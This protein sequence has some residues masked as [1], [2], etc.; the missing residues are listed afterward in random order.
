MRIEATEIPDLFVVRLEWRQDERG[1]FA[2]LFDGE[3]FAANGMPSHFLQ[4]SLSISRR[5]GTLRGMH[6]QRSPHAETKFV[7]CVRGAIYDVIADL[8]PESPSYLRWQAFEMAAGGDIALCIPK[9][10]AHGFQVLHDD[11]E[12][13][14]QM[15]VGH[16]P[17]YADG[18]RYDDPTLSIA[19]PLPVSV[20]SPKDLAWP[21]LELHGPRHHSQSF[22][23]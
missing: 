6:F 22:G 15:D 16:A 12:V 21:P 13:L 4:A 23:A 17:D 3:A 2:R 20:V 8:R 14:Y 19:W 1:A 7:R 9:G 18:V 11:T 10:C 5:T